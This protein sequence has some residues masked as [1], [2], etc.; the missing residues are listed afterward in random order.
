M[1]GGGGQGVPK[2]PQDRFALPEKSI[3]LSGYAVT[4]WIQKL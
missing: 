3:D 1:P 4:F 2:N